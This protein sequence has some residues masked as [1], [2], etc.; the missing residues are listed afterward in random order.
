MN[1]WKEKVWKN[2]TKSLE[3][4]IV[5]TV[6]MVDGFWVWSVV[7]PN[8]DPISNPWSNCSLIEQGQCLTE[9][10]AKLKAEECTYDASKTLFIK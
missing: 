10:E 7:K 2:Y 9:N 5:M 8:N 1:N 6:C 4:G 3:N